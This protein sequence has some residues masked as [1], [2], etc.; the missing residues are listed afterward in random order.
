MV[1]PPSQVCP[2]VAKLPWPCLLPLILLV[3][4]DLPKTC[5]LSKTL[6]GFNFLGVWDS[7]FRGCTLACRSHSHAHP[8]PLPLYC[9]FFIPGPRGV[10]ACAS[11][12]S[13]PWHRDIIS[14]F[15]CVPPTLPCRAGQAGGVAAGCRGVARGWRRRAPATVVLPAFPVC[16]CIVLALRCRLS[17]LLSEPL[18]SFIFFAAVHLAMELGHWAWAWAC[19]AHG[20]ARVP[21][22]GNFS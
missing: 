15:V 20:S 19:L 12:A 5:W 11:P 21:T 7:N 8:D 10:G 17:L 6:T 18:T 3:V 22:L 9:A 13:L 16:L 1:L 14:F 4:Q 2:Q